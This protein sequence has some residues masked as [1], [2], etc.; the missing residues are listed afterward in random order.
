[1]IGIFGE[2]LHGQVDGQ[3]IQT[4][5]DHLLDMQILAGQHEVDEFSVRFLLGAGRVDGV[6]A[7]DAHG[8]RIRHIVAQRREQGYVVV[9]LAVGQRHAVEPAAARLHGGH[10][11]VEQGIR[12]VV[13]D[14]VG[15]SV[16]DVA[17][18]PIVIKR[19]NG[20]LQRIVGPLLFAAQRSLEIVGSRIEVVGDA[21]PVVDVGD[22]A[23]VAKGLGDVARVHR[24]FGNRVQLLH[25]GGHLQ[26][27]F[28]KQIRVV[29][30]PH[31]F[32]LSGN[33]V[34][35][36]VALHGAL[37]PVC[38]DIRPA[39]LLEIRREIEQAARVKQFFRHGRAVHDHQ[40]CALT[41]GQ[42]NAHNVHQ[43]GGG[44]HVDLD[45]GM[46]RLKGLDQRL[47]EAL[48]FAFGTVLNHEVNGNHV[49]FG[50]DDGG[51]QRN[52]HHCRHQQCKQLLHGINLLRFAFQLPSLYSS[53]LIYAFNIFG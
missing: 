10:A 37:R 24:S 49:S 19:L 11:G 25:I 12:V 31:G 13:G 6:A 44:N 51:Q 8:Q 45:V 29:P 21:Q 16:V 40:I 2:Q 28:F 32:D 50:G 26:P 53:L 5:F 52:D 20:T 35:N 39:V 43:I 30:Q 42:L 23:A 27:Q 38:N 22:G 36:A 7:A 41:R 34:V 48:K 15:L 33:C 1:M 14:G 46:L 17:R 9:D 4:V 18:L 47:F 3:R